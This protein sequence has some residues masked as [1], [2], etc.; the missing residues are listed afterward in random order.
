MPLSPASH[1]PVKSGERQVGHL[2]PHPWWPPVSDTVT[3]AQCGEEKLRDEAEKPLSLAHVHFTALMVPRV[4]T[5]NQVLCESE[6]LGSFFEGQ[7]L[8][9]IVS[10][11]SSFF[12]CE[13]IMP[14]DLA[15]TKWG[16]RA[17]CVWLVWGGVQV[18]LHVTTVW[19]ASS[20]SS[21]C[22]RRTFTYCQ[23]H[24]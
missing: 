15:S 17:Q 6:S 8:L 19:Q 9:K 5:K 23:G 7:W 11:L 1:N 4:T 22:R 3:P 14:G 13:F 12:F 10:C 18:L 2:H 21:S 20:P 16:L 24:L